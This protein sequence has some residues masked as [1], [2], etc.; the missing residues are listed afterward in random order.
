MHV[1]ITLLSVAKGNLSAEGKVRYQDYQR[2]VRASGAE[3]MDLSGYTHDQV[4]GDNAFLPHIV[5]A[6]RGVVDKVRLHHPTTA[7]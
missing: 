2:F 5:E 1:P 6:V 4:H 3:F 7:P